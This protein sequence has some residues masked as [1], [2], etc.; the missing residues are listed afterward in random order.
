MDEQLF[1]DDDLHRLRAADPAAGAEASDALRKRVAGMVSL[2]STSGET[3]SDAGTA[4]GTAIG[5]VTGARARRRWLAPVAAAAAVLVAVGGGYAWGSGGGDLGPQPQAGPP[6]AVQT[7]TPENP[8]APIGGG[9]G[10]GGLSSEVG[11]QADTSFQVGISPWGWSG[12]HRFILPPLDTAPGHAEA[13][14]VD[15]TGTVSADAA[16]RIAGALGVAGEARQDEVD[17]G[18]VVGDYTGAYVSVRAGYA[19]FSSGLLYAVT[20]CEEKALA[21]HGR[22]KMNPDGT[23]AY[24]QEMIRCM[25]DTPRPSDELVQESVEVFLGAIGVSIDD[26]DIN[27]TRDENDPDAQ[28]QVALIV[29][30]NVTELTA[31]LTVSH[32]GIRNASGPTGAIVSLGDYAIVS[33][34]EAAARLSDPAFAAQRSAPPVSQPDVGPSEFIPEFVE[35]VPPIAGSALPWAVTEYEITSVRLG[36]MLLWSSDPSGQK[37]VPAYEFT[38][39]DG[40]VWSVIAVDE[41]MLDMSESTAP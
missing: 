32:E 12:R 21:L 11:A 31:H 41:S 1:G 35:P 33:P 36:L 9:D 27:V 13:F 29:D 17:L 28:V 18:W 19:H 15:A 3:D 20:V 23:W 37:L 2:G 14:G 34:A 26:V 30:D 7:G 5:A 6:I 16:T 4:T 22:D 39:A 8:G 38:T 25:A 24:G 10:G 40:S